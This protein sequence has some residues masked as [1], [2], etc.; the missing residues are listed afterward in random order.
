M[1][2]FLNNIPINEPFSSGRETSRMLFD[3]AV[4]LSCIKKDPNNNKVL[5]FACGT[6]WISEFLNRFGFD[7][8]GFDISTGA[9]EIAKNRVLAD[10]RINEKQ[11]SYFVSDAHKLSSIEDNFFSNIVCF[12]SLHHMKD[13]DKAFSEISRILIS[14][15]RAIFVEPGAKHSTSKETIEF[16]EKYKKDDPTWLERDI[17]LEEISHIAES[18]G[19]VTMR[20]KPFLSPGMVEFNL[21]DWISFKD[22]EMAQRKHL[23][24][25]IDF[26]YNGRVIFYLDKK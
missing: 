22:D 1:M 2:D 16:M 7:V 13:F 24:Q 9:I 4:M 3:F 5:D 14:G 20:I 17:V 11:L 10:K 25:I 26:N 18:N 19:L 8:Y 12:D 23:D 6:G 15:G 21:N